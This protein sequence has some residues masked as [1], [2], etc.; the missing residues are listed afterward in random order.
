M[1]LSSHTY[2]ISI[3][4]N[5]E[6]KWRHGLTFKCFVA[7]VIYIYPCFFSCLQSVWNLCFFPS[8][9]RLP[10]PVALHFSHKFGLDLQFTNCDTVYEYSLHLHSQNLKKNGL[11]LW[12]HQTKLANMFLSI[13][14]IKI[15]HYFLI[16][17]YD[18][19]YQIKR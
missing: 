4:L 16:I 15:F 5:S 7:R 18:K 8:I 14:S 12:F 2:F 3:P 1:Y 19:L 13:F 10:S 11:Y 6:N 17:I 9:H